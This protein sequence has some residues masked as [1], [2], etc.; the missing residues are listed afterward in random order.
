MI[1]NYNLSYFYKIKWKTYLY[2]FNIIHVIK[3]N[4]LPWVVRLHLYK[5]K[6]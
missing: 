6:I 4:N 1:I 3:N 2:H 5:L